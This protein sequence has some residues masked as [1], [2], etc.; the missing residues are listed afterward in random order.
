[1]ER[2][3]TFKNIL[4]FLGK[5]PF[6]RRLVISSIAISTV[7]IAGSLAYAVAKHAPLIIEAI[8]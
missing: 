1:M 6:V 5:Y 7:M 2:S 8:K 3:K 4:D